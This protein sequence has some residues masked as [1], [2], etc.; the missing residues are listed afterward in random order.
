M[1][2]WCIKD[3]TSSDG[4]DAF[5]VRNVCENVNCGYGECVV[6]LKK[7]PYYECKCKPPFQGPNCRS[8]EWAAMVTYLPFN[9]DLYLKNLRRKE[10]LNPIMSASVPA[11]P[12]DPNPC[13]NG[14]SCI[15]GDRRFH[16]ACPTGY[17]GKFCETGQPSLTQ[18]SRIK[19][20]NMFSS[21]FRRW[22]NPAAF[23]SWR[24]LPQ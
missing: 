21:N 12:C 19:T 18:W 10:T 5:P 16:C 13:K 15:I 7:H 9:V 4:S 17:T 8:C 2:L 24:I 11:S 23:C 3:C 22:T 20:R 14:A 1:V 6:N